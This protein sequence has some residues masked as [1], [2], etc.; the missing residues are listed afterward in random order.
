[1]DRMPPPVKL[2]F[3]DCLRKMVPQLHVSSSEDVTSNDWH[4]KCVAFFHP[5]KPSIPRRS[6]VGELPNPLRDPPSPPPPQ[7]SAPVPSPHQRSGIPPK[8]APAPS[9]HLPPSNPLDPPPAPEPLPG[10][11]DHPKISEPLYAPP[12]GTHP[13]AKRPPAPPPTPHSPT[14]KREDDNNWMKIAVAVAATAA[15]TFLFVALIF[16]CCLQSKKKKVRDAH[17]DDS[18]LLK[19]SSSDYSGGK[20]L[21]TISLNCF[22]KSVLVSYFI[23]WGWSSAFQVLHRN[24]I[25][26]VTRA[27]RASAQQLERILPLPTTY[28]QCLKMK[29]WQCLGHI[30]RRQM[31]Q[32]Q[33][34]PSSCH[35]V[36]QLHRLQGRHHHLQ[37]RHR[38]LL[39]SPVLHHP[40]R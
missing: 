25:A 20:I 4:L 32:W 36:R 28:Q 27:L 40:Q 8:G 17:K 2:P 34:L 6:L 29:F 35:Q 16:L 3:Q 11:P 7:S 5:S 9:R 38:H 12:T 26:S 15:A 33:F 37:G 1:M 13:T 18:P 39:L 21:T 14:K 31:H 10:S 22:G 23:N 24:H 19:L 30:R